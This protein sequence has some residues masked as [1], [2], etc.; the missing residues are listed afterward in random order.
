MNKYAKDTNNLP[1]RRATFRKR[2][3]TLPVLYTLGSNYAKTDIPRIHIYFADWYSTEIDEKETSVEPYV[4]F[5][6]RFFYKTGK[7]DAADAESASSTPVDYEFWEDHEEEEEMDDEYEEEYVEDSRE[8][9]KEYK[10]ESSSEEL[11]ESNSEE[12]YLPFAGMVDHHGDSMESVEEYPENESSS[13]SESGEEL[14]LQIPEKTN[15]DKPKDSMQSESS[16][17]ESGSDK[18]EEE[19]IPPVRVPESSQDY[20]KYLMLLHDTANKKSTWEEG[21]VTVPV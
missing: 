10:D 18:T 21:T 4:D 12:F 19:Y 9:F 2:C 11:Y 6:Q 8:E 16:E 15:N 1:W 20:I 13:S 17:E 14:Y 3:H 5:T 7:L